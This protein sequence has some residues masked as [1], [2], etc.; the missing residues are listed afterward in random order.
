M[1]ANQP[2][3][4][5]LNR[6]LLLNFWWLRSANQVKIKEESV[7]CMEKHVLVKKFAKELNMSLSQ[8]AWVEKYP[9]YGIK[10]HLAVSILR[11]TLIRN[12][13]L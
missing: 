4:S 2:N 9:G 1:P 13:A 8:W 3:D 10:I 11:S 12:K 5:V 6:G 7:T